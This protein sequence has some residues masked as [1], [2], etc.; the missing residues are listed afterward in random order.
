MDNTQG[1]CW[2]KCDPETM[3]LVHTTWHQGYAWCWLKDDD[4]GAF[5]NH[6]DK[7]PVDL[8]YQRSSW[9]GGGRSAN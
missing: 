2:S 8:Q 4:I 1:V 5:C 3:E 9:P 7:C 6:A